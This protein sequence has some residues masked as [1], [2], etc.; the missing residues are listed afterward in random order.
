MCD[1]TYGGLFT[2]HDVPQEEREVA[3]LV[4]GA[5][6]LFPFARRIIADLTRDGSF[7]TLML[8]PVDFGTIYAAK[9]KQAT[10]QAA[11]KQTS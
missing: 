4:Q 10:T 7:P 5:N 6:S 3:L 8:D 1:L 2:F 11:K 9:K